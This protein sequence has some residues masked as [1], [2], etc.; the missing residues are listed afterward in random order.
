MSFFIFLRSISKTMDLTLFIIM[1]IFSYI[2]YYLL[3]SIQSLLKEIKEIKTKCI[4][5]NNT[6]KEDF[7]IET[8]DPTIVMRE[9]AT[10]FLNSIK[11]FVDK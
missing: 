3:G 6:K 8:K 7:Q 9:K 1:V 4:H 2:L 5:T 11:Y 10:G